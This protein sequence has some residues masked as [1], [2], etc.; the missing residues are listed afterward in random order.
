MPDEYPEHLA[1]FKLDVQNLKDAE[2]S[3]DSSDDDNTGIIVLIAIGSAILVTA[4]VVVTMVLLKRKQKRNATSTSKGKNKDANN[5]AKDDFR[6][7]IEPSAQQ[8]PDVGNSN[9]MVTS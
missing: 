8:P 4:I 5:A 9:S 7:K 6:A 1:S 3:D 2:V